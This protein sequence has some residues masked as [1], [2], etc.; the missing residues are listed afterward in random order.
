M[1]SYYILQYT[2]EI[3]IK[4]VL[5]CDPAIKLTNKEGIIATDRVIRFLF[6]SAMLNSKNPFEKIKYLQEK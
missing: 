2:D 4:Y 5:P 6:Q 1:L 3:I